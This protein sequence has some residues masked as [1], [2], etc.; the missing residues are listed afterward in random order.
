MDTVEVTNYSLEVIFLTIACRLLTFDD[1]CVDFFR[2]MLLSLITAALRDVPLS[3][4]F[5]SCD[6]MPVEC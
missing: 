4:M 3:C 2:E 5:S 1:L 6:L